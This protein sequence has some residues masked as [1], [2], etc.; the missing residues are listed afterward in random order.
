MKKIIL[1][2]LLIFILLFIISSNCN[3]ESFA[4]SQNNQI[5]WDGKIT[6]A[7]KVIQKLKKDWSEC[8]FTGFDLK[9]N[10][11]SIINSKKRLI[12]LLPVTKMI[13]KLNYDKIR[14]FI[15]KY[16]PENYIVISKTIT[17]VPKILKP[18]NIIIVNNML[19]QST[20]YGVLKYQMPKLSNLNKNNSLNAS[21]EAT[22]INDYNMF[23]MSNFPI[24]ILDGKLLQ[25]IN[26]K[27]YDL[28]NK[29]EY[30]FTNVDNKIEL[31]SK[32]E[33]N[34]PKLQAIIN[35]PKTSRPSS[36]KMIPLTLNSP[37]TS[38]PSSP[39]MIPSTIPLTLNSPKTSPPS[40]PKTSAKERMTDLEEMANM[41][42]NPATFLPLVKIK[43]GQSIEEIKK[44]AEAE[45]QK[46]IVEIAI[47]KAIEQASQEL[48]KAE[49]SLSINPNDTNAKKILEYAQKNL[50]SIKKASNQILKENTTLKE[51]E[52]AAKK[53]V[54]NTII[55]DIEKAEKNAKMLRDIS[56]KNPN[57]K[58]A[59]KLADEANL[60][61]DEIKKKANNVINKLVDDKTITK[62]NKKE[63]TIK[64]N[65]IDLSKLLN[66]LVSVI[67][68]DG[69]VYI[70]QP[71]SVRPL[72]NWAKKL[73][74]MMNKNKLVLLNVIPHFYYINNK[75][76]FLLYF[77]FND[78]FCVTLN[79]DNL[80]EVLDV[81]SVLGTSFSQKLPD[82]LHCDDI[83]VILDQMTKSN[84][85]TNDK[86]KSLLKR[87]K[88]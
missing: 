87:Y 54:E 76:N 61:Y 52:K 58:N 43:P 79:K 77:I 59:K 82:R 56:N 67:E 78:D 32:K 64:I 4:N 7:D 25:K 6:T 18:R 57:D 88:C 81:K 65:E 23:N 5:M 1:I 24:Y 71:N 72:S 47:M 68:Y 60:K 34:K 41:S 31:L 69:V 19:Y 38:R 39:K 22:L 75:F 3:S 66:N 44:N 17:N 53:L 26:N 49:K 51:K 13:N 33:A 83:K 45:A 15:N 42:V 27:I 46:K 85:I 10:D 37:K 35:S 12:E 14:C 40:S 84:V 50:S 80:S 74:E 86:S 63:L 62:D 70:C 2:S 73:N 55:K 8:G 29:D 36:P 20:A 21:I 11:L 16:D 28:K 48:K 30:V 9:V